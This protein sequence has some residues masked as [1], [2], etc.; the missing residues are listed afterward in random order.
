VS[1]SK[2]YLTAVRLAR[3]GVGKDKRRSGGRA[4]REKSGGKRHE[5]T[6][7]SDGRTKEVFSQSGEE[8][9][10]RPKRNMP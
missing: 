6:H 5:K 9:P 1:A 10:S 3:K 4:R 7:R 2:R 8:I